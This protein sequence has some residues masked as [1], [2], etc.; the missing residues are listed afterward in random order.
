MQAAICDSVITKY[1][2]I[3]NS[4]KWPQLQTALQ[5]PA[6]ARIPYKSCWHVQPHVKPPLQKLRNSAQQL[7]EKSGLEKR[8][9]ELEDMLRYR[10]PHT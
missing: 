8:L 6:C 1:A 5:R 3:T 7:C 9:A 2:P 4:C 10:S